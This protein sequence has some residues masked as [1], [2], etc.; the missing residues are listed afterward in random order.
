MIQLPRVYCYISYQHLNLDNLILNNC[1]Y[2]VR[3]L[4]FLWYLN[5]DRHNHVKIGLKLPRSNGVTQR[6]GKYLFVK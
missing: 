5:E 6:N 3:L 2:V 1:L 4:D